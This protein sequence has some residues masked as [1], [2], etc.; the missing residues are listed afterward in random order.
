MFLKITL[1]AKKLS[2]DCPVWQL[3]TI[4]T[5]RPIAEWAA[6][7]LV[8]E[9]SRAPCGQPAR[10]GRTLIFLLLIAARCVRE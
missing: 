5:D 4:D 6:R 3:E 8:A 2:A 10:I 7:V 9:V 1:E